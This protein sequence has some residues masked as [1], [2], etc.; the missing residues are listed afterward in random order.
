MLFPF[1]DSAYTP[2]IVSQPD[3]VASLVA[4]S[5]GPVLSFRVVDPKDKAFGSKRIFKDFVIG[6]S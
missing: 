2:T 3:V 1:A 5:Q 6:L 4:E